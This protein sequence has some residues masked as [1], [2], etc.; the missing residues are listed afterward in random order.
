[1]WPLA[2]PCHVH[3]LFRLPAAGTASCCAAVGKHRLE[4]QHRGQAHQQGFGG[5]GHVHRPE[6]GQ[7]GGRGGGPSCTHK[8]ANHKEPGAA[9]IWTMPKSTQIHMGP[10]ILYTYMVRQETSAGANFILDREYRPLALTKHHR[11]QAY[12]NTTAV[13]PEDRRRSLA[14]SGHSSHGT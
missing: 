13:A 4:Q 12:L 5:I 14:S 11:T 6:G 1:M 10:S 7:G 3:V 9:A 2:L 8:H